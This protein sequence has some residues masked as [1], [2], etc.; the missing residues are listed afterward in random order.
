MGGFIDEKSKKNIVLKML[1][2]AVAD[3][4]IMNLQSYP[5]FT[6]LKPH[7]IYK[8]DLLMKFHPE[9]NRVN[10]YYRKVMNLMR[11][12]KGRTWSATSATKTHQTWCSN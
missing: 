12:G 11:N 8:A 1:P 5:T 7:A 4:L 9:S 10:I 3:H 6:A 2:K